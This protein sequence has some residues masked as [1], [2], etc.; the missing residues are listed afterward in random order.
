MRE[1]RKGRGS[2]SVDTYFMDRIEDHIGVVDKVAGGGD[3]SGCKAARLRQA[4]HEPTR[5]LHADASDKVVVEIAVEQ[6]V[7][8]KLASGVG[9]DLSTVIGV[10]ERGAA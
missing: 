3:L 10:A 1:G 9:S 4:H 7:L 6:D 8:H 2:S 5:V